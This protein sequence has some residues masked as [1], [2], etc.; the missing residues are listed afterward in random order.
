MTA[1]SCACKLTKKEF[2]K[3]IRT[4][5]TFDCS[6]CNSIRKMLSIHNASGTTIDLKHSRTWQNEKIIRY[7]K[8]IVIEQ[9]LHNIERKLDL[10][11]NLEHY[12]SEQDAADAEWYNS[13]DCADNG[14]SSTFSN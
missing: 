1:I 12:G 6:M 2:M 3:A 5:Q 8:L 14:S 4:Q 7:L 10:L 13:D 11:I 9:R